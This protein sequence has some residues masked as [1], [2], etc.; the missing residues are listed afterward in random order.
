MFY[1]FANKSYDFYFVWDSEENRRSNVFYS[2]EGTQV[3]NVDIKTDYTLQ[4]LEN[5][6][7]ILVEFNDLE[8]FTQDHPELF[9]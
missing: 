4:E 5:D 8:T 7:V 6:Y 2:L 1:L 3:K 9:L